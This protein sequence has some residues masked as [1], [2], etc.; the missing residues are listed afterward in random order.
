[1]LREPATPFAPRI[2]THKG[3][4]LRRASLR[5]PLTIYTSWK[6]CREPVESQRYGTTQ[7]PRRYVGGRDGLRILRCR[8]TAAAPTILYAAFL[9]AVGGATPLQSQASRDGVVTTLEPSRCDCRIELTRLISLSDSLHPGLFAYSPLVMRDSRGFWYA[10]SNTDGLKQVGVFDQEGRLKEVLGGLGE[11]P[12]EFKF[13]NHIVVGSG[14]TLYVYDHAQRRRSVFD[15]NHEFVRTDPIPASAWQIVPVPSSDL[16]VVNSSIPTRERVG[17]PLHTIGPDGG[18]LHSFGADPP[19][20]RPG[21][22]LLDHRGIAIDTEG[23]LWVAPR[24][25]YELSTYSAVG[26]SFEPTNRGLY[27]RQ[28]E[29]FQP[30]TERSPDGRPRPSLKQIAFGPEDPTLLWVLMSVADAEWA[31]LRQPTRSTQ[32]LSN[33]QYDAILEAIDVTS[34]SVLASR[35]FEPNLSRLTF[36][37]L[38][39]V[40]RVDDSDRVWMDIFTPTLHRR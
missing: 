27:R 9:G 35:R 17:W 25:A 3:C 22:A 11:G 28:V 13:I 12:G 20:A 4:A 15:P 38:I 29:W 19:L 36:Q 18:V 40:L 32:E 10:T 2:P 23:V 14:D 21:G 8:L 26:A 39:P 30:W 1:M 37:G 6:E 24:N 33:S 16:T 31:P 7:M 5:P 34:G